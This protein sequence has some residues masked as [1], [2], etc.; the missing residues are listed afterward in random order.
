MQRVSIVSD[1]TAGLSPGVASELGLTLVA[2][3]YAFAES[4]HLDGEGPDVYAQMTAQWSVPRTFG[5]AETAFR[6]AFEYGLARTESV[7]CLVTPFEVNP[8]FTTACAAMLAI[9]FETP[10]ARIKVANAGVGAA[11]LGALLLTLGQMAMGGAPMEALLEALEELEPQCDSLC[12]PET[13]EW[14]SRAGRLQLIEDRVGPLDQDL[15]IVRVGTRLTGVASVGAWSEGIARLLELVAARAGGGMLNACVLHA[16]SERAASEL[17]ARAR[18]ELPIAR[19]EVSTFSPTHGA[20]L[21]PGA[22]G[23]GVCPTVG[24]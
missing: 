16:G 9:Q 2:A 21:G 10:E 3:S 15:P 6:E 19:L 1:T 11:G 24:S 18:E 7:L 13:T 22:I 14:L 12:L 8:S 5:V 4:R 17:A 20:Q 23:I